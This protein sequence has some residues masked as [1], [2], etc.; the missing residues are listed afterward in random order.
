MRASKLKSA[1]VVYLTSMVMLHTL[2]FWSVRESIRKGYSDFTIYYGAGMILRQG[3]EHRLYDNVT[4]FK[5]QREFAPEVAIRLVAL[6]YNHPPFEAVIFAPFTYYSYPSAFVLWA[7]LNLG[8]LISLTF[9][10]RPELHHLQ[11]LPITFWMLAILGFFPIFFALLQGQDSILLLFLYTLAY[12]CLKKKRDVFAGCWLALGLF[13]PHLIL[14]L[15]C[16]L[17]VQGRKRVLYGFLPI[18]AVLVLISIGIVGTEGM[19]SYPHYV[20]HLEDR[21]AQGA[22]LPSDMPNLRGVLYVLLH[23]K[24][25][26]LLTVLVSSVAV[27]FFA[28][29]RCRTG[30]D[31]FDLKFSLAS[32]ATVLVSYHALGYDLSLLMLPILLI[33]NELLGKEKVSELSDF[34]IIAAIAVL[35]FSPIQF[36]LL[37][38]SNLLA[39]MGWAVL[40]LL[41]GIAAQIPIM[42]PLLKDRIGAASW[43]TSQKQAGL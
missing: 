4:Q 20:L 38:R 43:H 35:F 11:G 13:K 17:I 8:M 7:F 23:G 21:M 29:W 33:V 24:S 26:M 32:V 15:I 30:S 19:L 41:C 36:F 10:L 40:L 6:P 9:I 34:I 39:L 3:L 16:L 5:V 14:P 2:V 22:I 31:F 25:Y 37:M 42:P 12:L 28:A 27:L 1:V 18:S